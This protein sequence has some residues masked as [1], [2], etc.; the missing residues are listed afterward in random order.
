MTIKRSQ[1]L[2]L[3][4]LI[5]LVFQSTKYCDLFQIFFKTFLFPFMT[6]FLPVRTFIAKQNPSKVWPAGLVSMLC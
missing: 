2:L 4:L 6:L 1:N 5:L 3:G